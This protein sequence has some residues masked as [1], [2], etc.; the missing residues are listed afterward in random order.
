VIGYVSVYS[1]CLQIL[2]VARL[3]CKRAFDAGIGIGPR[4]AKSHPQKQISNELRNGCSPKALAL[5]L[6]YRI[7]ARPTGN[8]R[9]KI[10]PLFVPV[11]EP[12][13]SAI[14]KGFG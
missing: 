6:I 2:T 3:S 11:K 1:L 8:G 14:V 13:T 4:R 5:R 12:A 10:T 9:R 7:S